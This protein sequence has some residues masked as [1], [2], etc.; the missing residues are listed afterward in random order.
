MNTAC[1]QK[2]INRLLRI[3][4]LKHERLVFFK[5]P[6]LHPEREDWG[7]AR[8]CFFNKCPCGGS[9]HG[10]TVCFKII[11]FIKYIHS[12]GTSTNPF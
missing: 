6:N 8:R 11:H 5:V 12:R 4:S 7:E 3:D 9:S 1:P 2:D 10:I